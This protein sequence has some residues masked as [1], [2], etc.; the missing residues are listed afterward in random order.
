MSSGII[1]EF[2]PKTFA[3]KDG[4]LDGEFQG[5]NYFNFP[6][7]HHEFIESGVIGNP[8]RALPRRNG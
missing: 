2:L 6:T 1:S 5:Y 8:L 7:D 3:K 4:M